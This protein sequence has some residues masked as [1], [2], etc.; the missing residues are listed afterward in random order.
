VRSV[1]H[2]SSVLIGLKDQAPVFLPEPVP[3]IFFS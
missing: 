1:I 3:E 2:L